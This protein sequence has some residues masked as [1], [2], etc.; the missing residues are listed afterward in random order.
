V[1][2]WIDELSVLLDAESA[3]DGLA[4]QPAVAADSHRI[5]ALHR[6]ALRAYVEA[7]WGWDE[8]WQRAHFT[9]NFLPSANARIVD[10]TAPDGL[11]GRVSVSRHWRHLF[12]RDIELER[13]MRNRG[14]GAAILRNV[15]LLARR[16]QRAVELL[17]LDCNPA[18]ALYQRLGFVPVSGDGAR[19]RMRAT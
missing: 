7:T 1:A 11:R 19:T 13:S 14:I 5:Y 2:S 4:L 12:L 15:L 3:F 10:A 8:D 16:E 17:V 6:D 9:S 18:R